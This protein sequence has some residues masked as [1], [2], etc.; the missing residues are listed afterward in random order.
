MIKQLGN[1]SK[2]I[3]SSKDMEKES[4]DILILLLNSK[5]VI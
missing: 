3:L 1:I 2:Q 4:G 5:S